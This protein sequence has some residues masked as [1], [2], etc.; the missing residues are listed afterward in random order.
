MVNGRQIYGQPVVS[1]EKCYNE[2]P[3][4]IAKA[5][6]MFWDKEKNEEDWI[7]KCAIRALKTFSK[8][9]KVNSRLSSRGLLFH[10][11]YLGDKNILWRFE[12]IFEKESFFNSRFLWVNCFDSMEEWTETL[13]HKARL[14]WVNC[15]GIHLPCWNF[16]FFMQLGWQFGEPL[17]VEEDT[18]ARKRLD[19]RRFLVLIP[20]DRQCHEKINVEMSDYS[21]EVQISEDSV[22]V[23][24]S[25][26]ESYLGLF[27][28]SFQINLNSLPVEEISALSSMKDETFLLAKCG[29]K[30]SKLA[31]RKNPF[32]LSKDR[33]A[34][35]ALDGGDVV[36]GKR[37][38]FRDKGV[39][40]VKGGMFC[41]KEMKELPS[42]YFASSNSNRGSF[43][44]FQQLMGESINDISQQEGNLRGGSLASNA[45]MMSLNGSSLKND[46]L[47]QGQEGV[48]KNCLMKSPSDDVDKSQMGLVFGS[49]D[50]DS[51]GKMS[52]NVDGFPTIEPCSGKKMRGR[53]IYSGKRHSMVTRSSSA[54]IKSQHQNSK[55]KSRVVWNLEDQIAKV[56]ESGLARG[57]DFH[58][59]KREL[60]EIIAS[61]KVENDN[62]FHDLVRNL[63]FKYKHV[64][65]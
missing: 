10:S 62:R 53:K 47:L 11:S 57:A 19:I 61:R 31:V 42:K 13:I 28:T 20:H 5:K 21:F 29:E 25:W 65:S 49:K 37:C 50:V 45:I 54:A 2:G 39:S 44:D 4:E 35:I 12:T 58:G 1:K 40:D 63:V 18:Q 60:V 46:G 14:V 55:A 16:G 51:C 7:S 26:L 64:V 41:G 30:E 56:L 9:S 48:V 34:E 15:L 52:P 22:P 27:P 32:K 38:R 8:V 17:A 23:D 3:K 59:K 33:L 36:S 6:S 24:S 43:L